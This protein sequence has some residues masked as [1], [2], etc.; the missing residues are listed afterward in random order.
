[1]DFSTICKLNVVVAAWISGRAASGGG[2]SL[3]VKFD[4]WHSRHDEWITAGCGRLRA[5][6][7]SRSQLGCAVAGWKV[8]VQ[9]DKGMWFTGT[10]AM[11][12]EDTV[13]INS[14]T[15]FATGGLWEFRD[16][17]EDDASR[18]PGHRALR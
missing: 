16:A 3:L 13:A 4:G 1:M 10:V 6:N 7:D 15:P 11:F 18:R 8:R 17:V 5:S 14:D 12:D 2:W 9:L